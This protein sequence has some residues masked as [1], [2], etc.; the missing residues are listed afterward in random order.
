MLQVNLRDCED[1]LP[2]LPS[3]SGLHHSLHHPSIVSLHTFFSTSSA[4]Y[5]V[6]EY[7]PRGTLRDIIRSRWPQFLVEDEIRAILKTLT[8]AL[9]YLSRELVVHRTIKPENVL[10]SEDSRVVSKCIVRL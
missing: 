3:Y 9:V 5:Q 2:Q 7:C 4:H 1:A 6:L 10:V 8:S